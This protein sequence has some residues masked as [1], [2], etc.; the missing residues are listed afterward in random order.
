[1]SSRSRAK[2][3][4][5]RR[6]ERLSGAGSRPAGRSSSGRETAFRP[7]SGG[8]D[9]V[10][11]PRT[12]GAVVS[13]GWGERRRRTGRFLLFGAFGL[14]SVWV[15]LVLVLPPTVLRGLLEEQMSETFNAPVTLD[16]VR[17]N[18]F[19][20]RITVSGV[21]IPYAQSAQTTPSRISGSASGT[22]S[23][24]SAVPGGNSMLSV[25]RVVIRPRF[26]ALTRPLPI[27]ASVEAS[28]P[29]LDIAYLGGGRFSFSEL[30][31]SGDNEDGF[32]ASLFSIRDLKASGGTVILRDRPLGLVHV[33]RNI[34]LDVPLASPV[35]TMPEQ[36]PSLS[37]EVGGTQ[38][39][40]VGVRQKD[41]GGAYFSIRTTP[42]RMEYFRK[43]LAAFTPV[44]LTSGEVALDLILGISQ[45]R[46]GDVEIALSGKIH[47]ENMEVTSPTGEIVGRLKRG[48]AE[49]ERFT[50]SERLLRLRRMEL[51][52][53]YLRVNRD[54][55]GKI[56]WEDWLTSAVAAR[57]VSGAAKTLDG[58]YGRMNAVSETA[59][60]EDDDT[61]FMVEGADL[62]L[63]NSDFVWQDEKLAA[64]RQI[65]ITGVDGRIAEYSTRPG[66][67]TAMRLSFGISSEGV[68]ALEGEG[69]I[70]PPSLN[71]ALMVRDLP[72]FVARPLLGKTLLA[73][74]SG[75]ADLEGKVRL[76]TAAGTP[77]TGAADFMPVVVEDA[78]ATIRELT[79][80]G[81]TSGGTPAVRIGSWACDGLLLDTG[82][83][84]LSVSSMT[85]SEPRVRIVMD[86]AGTALAVPGRA[87]PSSAGKDIAQGHAL[88]RGFLSD[89]LPAAVAAV[90]TDWKLDVEAFSLKGGQVERVLAG[91]KV[92][93]LVS[94][95]ALE[96]GRMTQRLDMMTEFRLRCG[97]P[98]S[99]ELQG[100][101]RPVPLEGTM[102]MN[103][104]D[105][106][107][108]PLNVFGRRISD[109]NVGGRMQATLELG[110][111][112]RDGTLDMRASGSLTLRD[113]TLRN[114][115]TG[116]LFGG[117]R[118]LTAEAFRW[119][120][121]ARV[122]EADSLLVDKARLG[123]VLSADSRLDLLDALVKR[124]GGVERNAKTSSGL[125]DGTDVFVKR[126][127]V[128][129]GAVAFRDARR[130][131]E[132]VLFLRDAEATV[133]GLTR[134]K[135]G[136]GASAAVQLSGQLDGAPLSLTGRA[137]PLAK[138]PSASL[139]LNVRGASLE[140]YSSYFLEFLGYP[141]EQGLLDL[142]S[143]LELADGAFT[144]NNAI[145]VKKLV[146]GPKDTRP[147]AP[148]Y[149]VKL[150]LALLEDMRGNLS[151]DL[152]IRGRLD[153]PS[154]KV[155]GLVGRALG[156]LFARVVTS[157]F[158][159]V[160]SFFSLFMP[161]DPS[162]SLI[163]FRPGQAGLSRETRARLD[164]ITRLLE[165]RPKLKLELTGQ[166][167][168][169]GDGNGL[170][171]E[172]L[173]QQ[174]RN[175][176]PVKRTAEVRFSPEEHEKRLRT[177]YSRSFNARG[178]EE[179][180][181]MERRLLALE[182]V[183]E[184][185]LEAL[186]RL[187]AEAV[188]RYIVS[189]NAGLGSRVTLA[190]GGN[191]VRSGSAHVELSLR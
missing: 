109:L 186:A 87:I 170:R 27:L 150:G 127:R 122:F 30:L 24:A 69:T 152:P 118:R 147:G 63:R 96:T 44:R 131:P 135:N 28:R 56:D 140:R 90:L 191:A 173:L 117:I 59:A 2:R 101:L 54:R 65:E 88:P 15:L 124:R 55:T 133:S 11:L 33:I 172:R 188:R 50:L 18:P 103:A 107:L 21:R 80:A 3:Q 136:S 7:R 94:G 144:L 108:E 110:L 67:R 75:Y 19:T 137:D 98:K 132:L 157:P 113:V 58:G 39:S 57:S 189:K 82:G 142:E 32:V 158:S 66:A 181:V 60:T 155:E 42:L 16:A 1:M 5:R 78:G 143:R 41:S 182:T 102:R 95:L 100:R 174:L 179:A 166:Y 145:R 17:V 180:D 156:G 163:V 49:L 20:L 83:R 74:V 89:A 71:A 70:S 85:V 43:Y 190:K 72:L 34:A 37:A 4:A 139:T 104:S 146:L 51:D 128:Q 48:E 10:S 112:E 165:A 23:T 25:E 6:R 84:M 116:K 93:T 36:L 161:D 185:E 154:F 134:R 119:E 168:P 171:R 111:K 77:G 175:L 91:G 123:L 35:G 47:A 153:D 13:F 162:L 184:P 138:S 177:L 29:V 73:D 26:G 167:E 106:G 97:A 8:S 164:E 105:F 92:E 12:R 125:A 148:D 52:G 79:F 129:D 31:P 160:G 62:I 38:F 14:L 120:S 114:A 121:E 81:G 126:I 45:P 115:I 176:P 169:F 46:P 86:A 183:G 9:A 22:D 40:L 141:V 178:D 149:P 53:L 187:R 130:K 76:G 68:L 64:T 159:L 99:L 61:A 151:L